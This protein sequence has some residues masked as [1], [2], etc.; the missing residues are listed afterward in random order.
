MTV[1]GVKGLPCDSVTSWTVAFGPP[2]SG[3]EQGSPWPS[4]QPVAAD[5]VGKGRHDPGAVRNQ[6]GTLQGAAVR[7][8]LPSFCSSSRCCGGRIA[9]GGPAVAAAGV[10]SA[11]QGYICDGRILYGRRRGA[12]HRFPVPS[13]SHAVVVARRRTSMRLGD[14]PLR[15]AGWCYRGTSAFP[16]SRLS[17]PRPGLRSAYAGRLRV[18]HRRPDGRCRRP[19]L[20]FWT[21]R[22]RAGTTLV[23]GPTAPSRRSVVGAPAGPGARSPRSPVQST[24]RRSVRRAPAARR[25]LATEG[26]RLWDAASWSAL[27]RSRILST[28]IDER[29]RLTGG[30]AQSTRASA[31]VR[32]RRTRRPD[33]LEDGAGHH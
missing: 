18:H 4:L 17:A 9:I 12:G 10:A 16:S 25:A 24:W 2:E 30:L 23:P 31:R 32:R 5:P 15:Y 13:P 33:T 29:L 19:L 28:D 1:C 6:R 21:A 3:V 22:S 14:T 26:V 27:C 11:R 8:S 20:S 7:I